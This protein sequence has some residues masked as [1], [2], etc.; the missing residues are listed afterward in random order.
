MERN[1]LR[2]EKITNERKNLLS[3]VKENI[4]KD[5]ALL[6]EDITNVITLLNYD[7][8]NVKKYNAIVKAQNLIEELTKQIVEAETKEDIMTIRNKLNYYINKIKKEAVSR[9]ITEEVYNTYYE[10]ATILRKDIAKYLRFLKKEQRIEE[11]KEENSNYDNLTDEEK[12][13]LSKKLSNERS[14][15][16]RVMKMPIESTFTPKKKRNELDEISPKKHDRRELADIFRTNPPKR[17]LET[18]RD[19]KD[20]LENR[21]NHFNSMYKLE[22]PHTYKHSIIGNMAS[23]IKNIRIYAVNKNRI[24]KMDFDH[25]IYYRGEDFRAYIAYNRAN[26]SY[27]EGLKSIFRRSSLYN[28]ENLYL[29]NHERCMDWMLSF[30]KERDITLNYELFGKTI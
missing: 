4:L 13:N 7:N 1:D 22:K 21:L 17:S 9:G 6:K 18:F 28:K 30:I 14:Y 23:Y 10:H 12:K 25:Q 8:E 15:N 29:N 20:F 19:D 16:T 5:N 3:L 26:N 11:L 27:L 2:I 24:R